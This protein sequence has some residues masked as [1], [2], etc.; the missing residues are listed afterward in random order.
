MRKILKA[1]FCVIFMI[2]I[3]LPAVM[4]VF[5]NDNSENN[6]EKREIAAKPVLKTED[7]KIN[8]DFARDADSYISDNF[9][10]RAVLV[11]SLSTIKDV[12]FKTSAEDD[13]IIGKDGWLFYSRTLDDFTRKNALNKNDIIRIEKI[14]D[15]V[16][17]HVS[18]NGA[19]MVFFIAPNKNTIYEENMPYY[20]IPLDK[21]SNYEMLNEV[22]ADK[23]YY[24]NLLPVLLDAKDSAQIYHELDSH[25][26][27]LGAAIA[28]NRIMD[29]LEIESIDYTKLEYTIE[30]IH[31]GDLEGMLY[32]TSKKLDEQ[33]VFKYDAKFE[34]AYR[35]K[36]EEDTIM[37][38]ICSGND[39]NAMVYRDSFCNALLPMIA[40]EFNKVEF[41]RVFPYRLNTISNKSKFV[42]IELVER[43]IKNL[44]LSAP[45]MKAPIRDN[46]NMDSLENVTA[47]IIGKEKSGGLLHIYGTM[48]NASDVSD[49]YVSIN[50]GNETKI[51]EAFPIYETQL[52]DQTDEIKA[53]GFS[54]YLP[55][56]KADGLDIKIY[57]LK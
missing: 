49:V 23:D 44:L 22:M 26:N 9:G 21:A 36:S 51:F 14:M 53:G 39:Q 13:V 2:M 20:H 24:I 42:I 16:N 45:V 32:P 7:G 12:V 57:K 52:I 31:K 3:T 50:D 56:E 6:A 8:S 55:Y 17:E 40:D 34:Y 25:W 48:E 18:E 30:N 4:M 35:F 43:N 28:F 5:S 1:V 38:T 46:I 29:K 41:S 19:K 10:F 15:L 54:A 47:E 37:K 27:N 11:N 33:V